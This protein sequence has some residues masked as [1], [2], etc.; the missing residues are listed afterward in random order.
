MRR[1]QFDLFS[2]FRSWV[3]WHIGHRSGPT[4]VVGIVDNI[5]KE[6]TEQAQSR[7]ER[8]KNEAEQKRLPRSEYER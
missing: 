7:S 1:I 8:S 4:M 2:G 5:H 6:E 3:Q